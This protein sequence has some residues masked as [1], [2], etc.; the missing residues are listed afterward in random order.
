MIYKNY[1]NLNENG[2]FYFPNNL[3]IWKDYSYNQ[4]E[5]IISS[6]AMEVHSN[7][8]HKSYIHKLNSVIK[9]YSDLFS[10]DFKNTI[11]IINI[12]EDV[13][14]E[15]HDVQ[16]Q[17]TQLNKLLTRIKFWAGGHLNHTFFWS[18]L[19]TESDKPSDRLTA[20][21]NNNF[22]NFEL[23]LDKAV[24][25]MISHLGSGWLWLIHKENNKLEWIT[26]NNHDY[27]LKQKPILVIDIWEHAY[28]LDY[29]YDKEA[30]FRNLFSI[31]DWDMVEYNLDNE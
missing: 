25:I 18:I 10:K 27:P 28:Y 29:E 6:H 21:I 20:L 23:F 31:I 5:K 2:E 1:I 19:R 3:P 17:E 8:H 26:T 13:N 11:D 24:E 30:F 7:N 9:K 16:N 4:I 15:L 14:T 12:C 22:D